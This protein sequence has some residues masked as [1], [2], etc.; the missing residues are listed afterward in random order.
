MGCGMLLGATTRANVRAL[1]TRAP[2]T[3]A[4]ARYA[5]AGRILAGRPDLADDA[6]HASLLAELDAWTAALALPRLADY[7]M[8][9]NDVPAVVA[10]SRGSSMRTNPVVLEDAELAG[11]L[12]ACI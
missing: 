12:A 3:P 9:V 2:D 11:I 1:S 10:D 4:L 8:T 6:A 7:G 5:E